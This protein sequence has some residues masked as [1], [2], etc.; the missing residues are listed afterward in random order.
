MDCVCRIS[1]P[2]LF[3]LIRVALASAAVTLFQVG[4]H[5]SASD[6]KSRK[7]SEWKLWLWIRLVAVLVSSAAFGAEI[8]S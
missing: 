4:S 2:N 7:K 6:Y 3:T 1:S 5:A 8:E